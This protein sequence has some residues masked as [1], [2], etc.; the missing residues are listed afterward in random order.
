MFARFKAFRALSTGRHPFLQVP[1]SYT[2]TGG[3]ITG[4]AG[5]Q[6]DASCNQTIIPTS[7]RQLCKP[8]A[9]R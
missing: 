7:L 6:V 9:T 5:N 1:V 8:T 2:S 4:P 3:T